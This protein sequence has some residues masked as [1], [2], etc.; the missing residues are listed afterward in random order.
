MLDRF[1]ESISKIWFCPPHSHV[2]QLKMNYLAVIVLAVVCLNGLVNGSEVI[3][4][5]GVALA[6][7]WLCSGFVLTFPTRICHWSL[8]CWFQ[9]YLTILFL[10]IEKIFYD[11]SKDFTCIDGSKTI[12][13][14]NV[15][16]DYCDCEADG[17]DEPGTSACANGS[18][19]CTNVG[20]LEKDIYSSMVNDGIC[21]KLGRWALKKAPLETVRT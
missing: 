15:N 14:K 11:P 4:P 19:H 2:Q 12:P 21:G 6:S 7:E 8:F 17:S 9:F 16:D 5:R 18:F 13:F 3:R 1:P 10:R 20:Y